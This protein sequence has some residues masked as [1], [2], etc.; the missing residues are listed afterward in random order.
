M[1]NK[2]EKLP[3]KEKIAVVCATCKTVKPIEKYANDRKCACG[4]SWTLISK[5]KL[6]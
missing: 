2:T 6:V 4:G 5:D 1:L 3:T